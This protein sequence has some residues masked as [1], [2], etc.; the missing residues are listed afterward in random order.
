MRP[1]LLVYLHDPDS[2]GMGQASRL[3]ASVLPLLPE[4]PRVLQLTVPGRAAAVQGRLNPPALRHAATLIVRTV[5]NVAFRRGGRVYIPIAQWGLPLVRDLCLVL[6]ARLFGQ[7]LLIHLHGTLLARRLAERRGMTTRL[8]RAILVP[9]HWIALTPDIAE[10]LRR[11]GVPETR[12]HVVR[13]P[14]PERVFVRAAPGSVG[15]LGSI[16]LGKGADIAA[17]AVEA[18][19]REGRCPPLVSAGPWLDVSEASRAAMDYLGEVPRERLDEVFWPRC[20]ILLLPARW[21]EGL[22]F[23]VLE[24]LQRDR[25]VLATRSA[26]LAELMDAG[27]VA[28]APRDVESLKVLLREVL[29]DADTHRARQQRAWRPLEATYSANAFERDMVRLLTS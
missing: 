8:L 24:G 5:R 18:L 28:E 4:Q 17:A 12:C 15:F 1:R 10:L 25:V 13:N 22:P 11:A 27:A 14:A 26:G 20:A 16:C 7:E 19:V 3:V 21:E 29:A 2:G 9:A 6:L 23:V